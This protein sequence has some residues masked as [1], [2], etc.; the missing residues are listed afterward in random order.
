VTAS[1]VPLG[2]LRGRC[3]TTPSARVQVGDALQPLDSSAT[4]TFFRNLDVHLKVRARQL[5]GI[6]RH[7]TASLSVWGAQMGGGLWLTGGPSPR[8][9]PGRPRA[10]WLILPP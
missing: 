1:R 10:L 3:P 9:I 5:H 6:L 4:M 8:G 2:H 7:S